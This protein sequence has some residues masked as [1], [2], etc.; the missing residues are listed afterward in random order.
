MGT[1]PG[2]KVAWLKVEGVKDLDAKTVR[3]NP[4]YAR[5]LE[6]L[7]GDKVRARYKDFTLEARVEISEGIPTGKVQM[8]RQYLS[9]VPEGKALSLMKL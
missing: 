1:L 3:V 2:K 9:K 4:K 8:D 7:P 5:L 6:L